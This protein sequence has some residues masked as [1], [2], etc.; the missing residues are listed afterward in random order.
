MKSNIVMNPQHPEW[1]E[2]VDCMLDPYSC[3]GLPKGIELNY[4]CDHSLRFTRM[5]LKRFFDVNVDETLEEFKQMGGHCDCKVIKNVL[6]TVYSGSKQLSREERLELEVQDALL[7]VFS[8][9]REKGL[10]GDEIIRLAATKASSFGKFHKAA[11]EVEQQTIKLTLIQ[12][13]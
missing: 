2:F 9:L 4:P 10:S 3:K 12:G 13:G 11:S 5:I 1:E 8:R 6:F 7:F